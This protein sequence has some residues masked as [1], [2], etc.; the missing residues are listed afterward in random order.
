[1]NGACALLAVAINFYWYAGSFRDF[2]GGL[3]GKYGT[4]GVDSLVMDF[5]Y[6]QKG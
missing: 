3:L 4:S 2:V 6:M 5:R 1:M